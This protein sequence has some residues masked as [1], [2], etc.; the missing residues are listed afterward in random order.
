MA[1][2]GHAGQVMNGKIMAIASPQPISIW[3][4][5]PFA[6]LLVA[7]ALMP[8][9]NRHW[10][11]KNY[12]RVSIAL[13]AL[14]G[15]YYL[16]W[17]RSMG[18]W[19]H[20]MVDYLSFI[21]LLG[22]LYV[23]SGGIVITVGRKATPLTN[24]VLLLFGAM[25]SNI[26]GTTGASMLLIRP[27]LRMNQAHL[28]PYHVVFFIFIVSNAGGMLT[29]IGDPPL[30][31]GFLR[32]VPFWWTLEHGRWPWMLVIGAML[33]IFFV[34]ESFD[35]ARQ[36]RVHPKDPGPGVHIIGIHNFL[37]VVVIVACVFR[38]G[39][40]EVLWMAHRDGIG[41]K[42]ILRLLFCREALML[43]SAVASRI[44]TGEAIYQR[45]A[46][47]YGPIK[48]VAI[49]F[50]GLFSTMSPALQWLG[51]N[52]QRMAPRTAG[53]YYFTTGV[54]S[55]VLDSAPSYLAFFELELGKLP[56]GQIAAALIDPRLNQN[57]LAIALGAVLFGAATYI[58]NGP[59]FMVKSIAEN[60]G[61][62]CPSF[63]GYIFH[64]SLPLLLP[65]LIVIWLLFLF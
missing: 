33:A 30:F 62:R 14:V 28:R 15:V 53:Q 32:G 2:G 41:A 54:L 58:G 60:A 42:A 16:L 35:R 31:L 52:S 59:N 34:L 44:L 29:P 22:S 38:E 36:E 45:N 48:E 18:P 51:E 8:M 26:L 9:V 49:L 6:L 1:V 50:F 20:N 27:F 55:A 11:E 56:R 63:F 37:F 19:V 46:F 65:I 23:V 5:I 57:L 10:W 17:A 7:I 39:F 43:L 25:I 4:V 12:G 47:S 64:Y 13:A 40:G 3:W 21:I 61:V 24:C